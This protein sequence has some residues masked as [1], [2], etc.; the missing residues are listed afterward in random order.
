M[1]VSPVSQQSSS[2]LITGA[3]DGLGRAMAVFLAANGY[4]VFAAGR[5]AEKRASL[6]RL[7]GEKKLLIETLDLDVTSDESVQRG[8]ARVLERAGQIDVLINNAGV[9]FVAVVEEIGLDDLR[10]QFETNVFG[11]VRMLQSVLPGMRA[12]R[13]GRVVN[14]SS[15][16]GKIST[17]PMGIYSSSKFALEALSDALRLE[18]TPFGV[19]VILIEP[20]YIPTNMESAAQELSSSYVA[21]A[22]KSPYAAVYRGFRHAWKKVTQD[23]RTT[24]EDCARVILRSLLETPPR[25]RYTVTRRA[26]YGV[27][28]KRLLPDRFMDKQILKS[29]GLDKP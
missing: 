2:V 6:E 18:L 10:R 27:I 23:A 22:E 5:N 12:R 17:P 9:A 8:V 1:N 29:M 28:A 15:I 19:H 24:P 4:R 11:A 21:R 25:P 3:T 16:A 7:A 13:S 26:R 14:I 20:G